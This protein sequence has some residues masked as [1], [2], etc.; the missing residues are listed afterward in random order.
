MGL[1]DMKDDLI[2]ENKRLLEE[3][4]RLKQKISTTKTFLTLWDGGKDYSEEA[5]HEAINDAREVLVADEPLE[6]LNCVLEMF[7]RWNGKV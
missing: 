1:S 6:T 3:N 2:T 5:L 4:K 7:D